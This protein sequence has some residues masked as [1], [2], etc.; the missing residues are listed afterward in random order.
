MITFDY[1]INNNNKDKTDQ[2][3]SVS[4]PTGKR[5]YAPSF[6][7]FQ[8]KFVSVFKNSSDAQNLF[9]NFSY[10]IDTVCDRLHRLI[11]RKKCP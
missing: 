2:K 11:K 6:N 1:V 4:I 8:Q 9:E 7:N 5:C 3:F 10:I